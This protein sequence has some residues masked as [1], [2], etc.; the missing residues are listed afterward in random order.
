MKDLGYVI[1]PEQYARV[2][3]ECVL[4]DSLEALD[5][6]KDFYPEQGV[7]F[8]AFFYLAKVKDPF[9]P[10][11]VYF[12]PKEEKI[13]AAA[14]VFKCDTCDFRLYTSADISDRFYSGKYR[15]NK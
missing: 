8:L 11:W 6:F 7:V 13:I 5:F 1:R 14:P 10:V 12:I 2:D 4:S 9:L 3:N 15:P